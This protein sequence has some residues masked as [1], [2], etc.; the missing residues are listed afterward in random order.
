MLCN[1]LRGASISVAISPLYRQSQWRNW[2]V[3]LLVSYLISLSRL[4]RRSFKTF[5]SSYFISALF[6]TCAPFCTPPDRQLRHSMRPSPLSQGRIRIPGL[7][8]NAHPPAPYLSLPDSI[9]QVTDFLRE[10]AA[11]GGGTV[12]LTGAGVSVDS[13]IR[14]Y[15]GKEGSYTM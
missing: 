12:C 6:G 1:I 7:K 2:P 14:A 10:G 5:C 11:G 3:R 15:R 8:P 9:A 13:G 4:F